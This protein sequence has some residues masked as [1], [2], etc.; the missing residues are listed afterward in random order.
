[1]MNGKD[2]AVKGA[3]H[4]ERIIRIAIYMNP[5]VAIEV[6]EKINSKSQKIGKSPSNYSFNFRLTLS[7]YRLF[8]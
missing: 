2:S 3:V 7:N 6:T 4:I 8:R 1:M 5:L